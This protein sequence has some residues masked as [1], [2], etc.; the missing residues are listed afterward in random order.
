M[1][2]TIRKAKLSDAQAIVRI[3]KITWLQA[4]IDIEHNFTKADIESLPWEWFEESWI[5][6]LQDGDLS[7]FCFVALSDDEQI[8]Y[9]LGQINNQTLEIKNIYILPEFQG[10]GIGKK[11]ATLLYSSTQGLYTKSLAKV[12]QYNSQAIRFYQSIGFN[13]KNQIDSFKSNEQKSIPQLE[14]IKVDSK[15]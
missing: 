6:R 7:R 1:N 3:N 10:L 15:S 4:Y 8:G 14:L 11:L 2:I 5:K 13:N 9:I 12:A